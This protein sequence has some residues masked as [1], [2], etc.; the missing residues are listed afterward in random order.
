MIANGILL[1]CHKLHLTLSEMRDREAARLIDGGPKPETPD[2]EKRNWD[3][4]ERFWE[5]YQDLVLH[6]RYTLKQPVGEVLLPT[7][8]G[9]ELKIEVYWGLAR[10]RFPVTRTRDMMADLVP[11]IN[12]DRIRI[13]PI[14]WVPYASQPGY[15]DDPGDFPQSVQTLADRKRYFYLTA[16]LVVLPKTGVIMVTPD[17]LRDIGIDQGILAGLE[18][19]PVHRLGF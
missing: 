9:F 17:Q 16:M 6:L 2:W 15:Y 3:N 11:I 18:P 19:I 14:Q 1:Y 13:R 8:N 7:W 4:D 5:S 12:P 10:D